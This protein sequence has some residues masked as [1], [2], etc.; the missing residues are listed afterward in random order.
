MGNVG[1]QRGHGQ[2][3]ALNFGA[4]QARG[5]YLC[6]LD[7]DD[8]WTDPDHLGRAAGV[9]VGSAEPIDLLLAN[10]RAYRDNV[11]V[12]GVIW[13]EDLKDRLL[14]EPD[15]AGAYT[16]IRAELLD[17]PAHCHLNTTISHE[18]LSLPF[19]GS[20][21]VSALKRTATFF[22]VPSIVPG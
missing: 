6:F 13:I 11:P 16:V 18:P 17:C 4:G 7:D 20:A 1:T 5:D 21:K 2:G 15:A 10:Q 12:P 3:F 22:S 8:Q 19:P 14:D 9:I